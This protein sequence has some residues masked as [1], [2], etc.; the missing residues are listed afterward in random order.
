LINT[1]TAI[2][3]PFLVASVNKKSTRSFPFRLS[4]YGKLRFN[5]KTSSVCGIS[6]LTACRM[7][8][9]ET[10]AFASMATLNRND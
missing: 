9:I 6:Q 2:M 7:C 3:T 8:S 10:G 1:L 4:P 5:I